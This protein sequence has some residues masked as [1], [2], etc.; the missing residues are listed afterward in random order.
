MRTEDPYGSWVKDLPVAYAEQMLSHN[1][2]I[3]QVLMR[4]K[5]GFTKFKHYPLVQYEEDPL[6][7]MQLVFREIGHPLLAQERAPPAMPMQRGNKSLKMTADEWKLFLTFCLVKGQLFS[8]RY[9]AEVFIDRIHPAILTVEFRVHLKANLAVM[10]I[11]RPLPE[12]FWPENILQYIRDQ[13]QKIYRTDLDYTKTPNEIESSKSSKNTSGKVNRLRQ[14]PTRGVR[15]IGYDT[16]GEEGELEESDI[17]TE[18]SMDENELASG[19]IRQLLEESPL[20]PDEL[21]YVRQGVR[22]SG[23]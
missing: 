10:P 16:E 2:A 20:E 17:D 9:F 11:D 18:V 12:R 3:D 19:A 5:T 15:Q 21:L 13:Y 23:N 1:V 7:R 6:K 8:D 14:N 22:N 4:P